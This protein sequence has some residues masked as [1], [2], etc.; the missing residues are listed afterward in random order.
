[1]SGNSDFWRI[2]LLIGALVFA[3]RWWGRFRGEGHRPRRDGGREV[4]R[5]TIQLE[6]R[7]STLKQLETRVAELENRLDFTERLLAQSAAVE[8]RE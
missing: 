1:M 4:A 5:G 7:L 2:L 6:A 3:M 8:N